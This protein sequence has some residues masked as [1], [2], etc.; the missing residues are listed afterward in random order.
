MVPTLQVALEYELTCSQVVID[1]NLGQ[2][3]VLGGL[4][5]REAYTT[6]MFHSLVY[7]QT[8]HVKWGQVGTGW[9]TGET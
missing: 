7:A 8:A 9:R 3:D 4:R 5:N 1:D 2:N 6:F